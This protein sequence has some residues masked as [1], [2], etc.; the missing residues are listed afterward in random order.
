MADVTLEQVITVAGNY[1]CK[2][3]YNYSFRCPIC[4]NEG[5]D[6]KGD[7][8]VYN[9]DKKIVKCF[10][11]E[12][13][14]LDVLA[15]INE[16]CPTK[17]EPVRQEQVKTTPIW[18]IRQEQYIEYLSLTQE[19]LLNNKELLYYL[20]KKRG[21]K[22]LVID[23]C[24]IGFDDTE[25][26][27]T[28]PIFSL[29]HDCI[30]DFELRTKSEEKQIRRIGGGC[31]TIAKIWGVDKAKELYIVEG[32]IDGITL[33]QWL[34]ESKR[35]S[36]TIYSCSNGVGSL[37]NCLKEIDFSNFG[38]VKLILD[39]DESGDLATKQIIDKYKFIQDSRNFLVVSG[40]K[41]INEYYLRKV[42][43]NVH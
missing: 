15:L 7:N 13:H 33:A 2:S 25:N 42:V 3:G 6:K 22:K 19:K 14:S 30:T 8:L 16:K 12:Y 11:N 28:I 23:L 36:F 20:Y 17:R 29:A 37:F 24:G 21:L 9:A 43:G 39:N 1:T 38:D 40:C 34:L 35:D 5:H 41:D 32:F 31:A 18:E 4:A 27:F 26:C 10:A